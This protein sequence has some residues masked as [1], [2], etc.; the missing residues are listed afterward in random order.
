MKKTLSILVASALSF[1]LTACGDKPQ[2]NEQKAPVQNTAVTNNTN[3]PAN[4]TT[5]QPV[6]APEIPDIPK[7][8]SPYAMPKVQDIQKNDAQKD[9][10]N[11]QAWITEQAAKNNLK[12]KWFA[13]GTYL[14]SAEEQQMLAGA[15]IGQLVYAITTKMTFSNSFVSASWETANPGTKFPH[16]I[17]AFAP[18]C[19]DTLYFIELNNEKELKDLMTTGALKSCKMLDMNAG[20]IMTPPPMQIQ[21]NQQLQQQKQEQQEAPQQL[22][23]N[24]VQK[25]NPQQQFK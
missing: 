11:L 18:I 12:V 22:Q 25:P 7:V 9:K 23:N 3:N 15:P 4:N 21:N 1:G 8:E 16:P 2:E 14:L 5:Q 19:G 6:K 10:G 20:V 24:S 13:K 17:Y